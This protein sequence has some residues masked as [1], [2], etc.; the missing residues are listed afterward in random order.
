MKAYLAPGAP[1]LDLTDR[2]FLASGGEGAIYVDV[3][4]QRAYKVFHD[5]SR[6]TPA[7]KIAELSAIVDP[8]VIKPEHLLFS[9]KACRTLIGHDMRFV[10]H[11]GQDVYL[12][13]QLLARSFR[14]RHGVTMAVMVDVVGQLREVVQAVHTAGCL[15]VDLK[16][17]NFLV[18]LDFKRL[19]AIDAGAYHTRSFPATAVTPTTLDPTTTQHG[20]FTVVTDWYAFAVVSCSLFLGIHPFRGTYTGANK[21]LTRLPTDDPKDP[22]AA[23]RRRMKAGVSVFSKDVRVPPVVYPFDVIPPAWR[24]WYE[25]VFERGDRTAPPATMTKATA[26]TAVPA[27][28]TPVVAR[29][30]GGLTMTDVLRIPGARFVGAWQVGGRIVTLDADG[31]VYVDGRERLCWPG[32]FAGQV[33]GPA[34]TS[35]GG[36]VFSEFDHGVLD[37]RARVLSSVT[38]LVSQTAEQAMATPDGRLYI[39][40][41]DRVQAVELIELASGLTSAL[42][43]AANCMPN[44]TRLWPGVAV[45]EALGT[46][47]VSVFPAAGVST[48]VAVKELAGARVVAGRGDRGVVVLTV[49]RGGVYEFGVVRV[50][51]GSGTYDY[52]SVAADSGE[53]GEPNVAVTKSGTVAMIVEDGRLELFSARPGSPG[54]R[55]VTDTAVGVEARLFPLDGGVGYWR[56]EVVG[57]LKVGV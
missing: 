32:A 35:G 43:P 52:R 6:A 8:R 29:T 54:V 40:Q 47:F 33:V 25:A 41:G 57:R 31:A 2:N 27:K 36:V 9:D 38:T 44:A 19:F 28:V 39:K 51:V 16:E 17:L 14:D 48:T 5:A 21:Q 10:G 34:A 56:G 20:P 26:P 4:A 13:S 1:A 30:Q 15:I 24:R 22:L 18:S 45:Q 50:D 11:V 49:V 55:V 3:A 42:R 53:V 37:I 12:L 46:T 23:V 7:A